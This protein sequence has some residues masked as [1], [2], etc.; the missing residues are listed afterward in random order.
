[1]SEAPFPSDQQLQHLP[2]VTLYLS[3]RCNSRCVSCDWWRSGHIDMDLA[4]AARLLPGLAELQTKVVLISGGEPLLNPR[5]AEIA[6]LLRAQGLK[7]W[8]LTSGLSLA[9][10]AKRAAQL[11]EAITVSLDGTTA[12]SYAGIRGVDAFD[13]V[14]EGIRAA[15]AA[16]ASVG[17]RVTVQRA[18]YRQLPQFVVLARE[19]GARQISFVAV[20]VANTDA[21]GRATSP[22][23]DITLQPEDLPIFEQVLQRLERERAEDFESGLIADSARKLRRMQ[24][25]FRAVC[26]LGP[27]PAV[28][29]NVFEFSA[30]IDASGHVRPC[31]FIPGPASDVVLNKLPQTLNSNAMTALRDQ[32]RSGA[33]PECGRC[34]CSL[35]RDPERRTTADFLIRSSAA[36]A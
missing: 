33:R 36:H 17:V 4:T 30:V 2:L 7:L 14:C 23:A 21:F 15:A 19:L 28:R 31:F 1:M 8:L 9:K 25:Y 10:H 6:A 34:V 3:E 11:F 27:Y 18:N 29:C 5:W 13:K 26:G 20:D 35:W 12:E 24:Q 32:I 22:P 16:G